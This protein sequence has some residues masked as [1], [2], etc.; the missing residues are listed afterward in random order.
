MSG[1]LSVDLSVCMSPKFCGHCIS[2]TNER[3]LMKLYI[4]LHLGI[5]WCWLVLIQCVLLKKFRC[6]SKFY[7]SLKLLYRTKLRAFVLNANY[8][9]PNILKFKTFIYNSN[10][11]I[12]H[13]FCMCRSNTPPSK[14]E[15][16][17]RWRNFLTMIFLER[18]PQNAQ[19]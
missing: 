10:S 13:N 9:K 18:E 5:I 8:F 7:I 6:C 4:Q 12:M 16:P 3:K 11:K 1:Y 14:E 2:R 15:I 19:N 17:S